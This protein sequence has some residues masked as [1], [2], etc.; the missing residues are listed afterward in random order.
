MLFDILKNLHVEDI[1]IYDSIT[2]GIKTIETAGEP[3]SHDLFIYIQNGQADLLVDDTLLFSANN[4]VIYLPFN[5]KYKLIFRSAGVRFVIVS[6]RLFTG[7]DRIILG[8]ES[9][10][11]LQGVNEAFERISATVHQSGGIA[12]L[13]RYEIFYSILRFSIPSLIGKEDTKLSKIISGV[14]Q[15]EEQFLSNFPISIYAETCGL[16]E[17]RFRMLFAEYFE[18]TPVE[19][20]NNLRMKY[21]RELMDHCG[22]SV[23]EAARAS[24]F[25]SATYFCR[26]HR[27]M[28]G[29]S[30]IELPG[31]DED[32]KMD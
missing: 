29:Y 23:A 17:N 8:G 21:A 25:N 30:P 3:E 1:C 12:D 11:S 5:L 26:L 6:F 19:Y 15:L 14:L 27:K 28:F 32:G 16:R 2:D 10:I 31:E 9:M 20:R 4:T 22:C 24:G 18:M 13:Y 7:S